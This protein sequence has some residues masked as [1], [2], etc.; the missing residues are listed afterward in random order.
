MKHRKIALSIL[1]SLLIDNTLYNRVLFVFDNYDFLADKETI[2]LTETA[3][4]EISVGKQINVVK[5][6]A[7]HPEFKDA[8]YEAV[9]LADRQNAPF[10]IDQLLAIYKKERLIDLYGNALMSLKNEDDPETVAFNVNVHLQRIDPI[11]RQSD[12]TYSNSL[13]RVAMSII[14]RMEHQDQLSGVHT[15]Y[16]DL[17][18]ITDGYQKK[19]LIITGGRPGMGKTAESLTEAYRIAK[20]GKTV[21]YFSLEMDI[22]SINRR[23]YAYE[24]NV[25]VSKLRRG[26]IS[27]DKVN[28]LEKALKLIL[29]T[30]LRV[31]DYVK[32]IDEIESEAIKFN[33]LHKVDYIVIDYCQIIKNYSHREVRHQVTDTCKRVKALAKLL[34]CPINL[35][36]QL[37]RANKG[38]PTLSDLKES[39]GIEENADLVKLLHRPGYYEP[40][41]YGDEAEIIVAK[42]R[43]GECKILNR[44]FGYP[45]VEY[46]ENVLVGSVLAD[47][48]QNDLSDLA[49]FRQLDENNLF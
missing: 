40:E 48:Q 18:E 24:L 1:G 47:L 39:G 17:N 38:R 31:I 2:K 49:R 28:E 8:I 42:N 25:T 22:D 13:E 30:P 34:D 36:A 35:L 37:S 33:N 12:E 6:E 44:T 14:H 32:T 46:Q 10:Y 11:K 9:L 3:C 43:N 45:Y 4:K 41:E 7:L 23:L 26:Q 15:S 16:N 5:L 21:L 19:D 20:K 29:D 27:N